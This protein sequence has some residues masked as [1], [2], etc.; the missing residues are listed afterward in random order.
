MSQTVP[1]ASPPTKHSCTRTRPGTYLIGDQLADHQLGQAHD[2]LRDPS[3]VAPG[4]ESGARWRASAM[5]APS[6]AKAIV[7]SIAVHY[8]HHAQAAFRPEAQGC[9]R[10]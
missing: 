9:R 8:Q 4:E 5:P 7:I 6:S 2:P 3:R 10:R 1:L